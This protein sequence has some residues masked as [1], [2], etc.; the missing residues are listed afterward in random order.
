MNR[1]PVNFFRLSTGQFPDRD[2]IEAAREII[3]RSLMKMQFELRPDVPFSVDMVFRALP[4]FALASG[5]CSAMDC[6]RT[7]E[8]IESNDLILTVA[9]SGSCILHV[10]GAEIPIDGANAA[11]TRTADANRCSIQ[12]TSDLIN[13]RFPFDKIAPLIADLDAATMRP[14]PINTEALRLL[15]HYAAMLKG[16]DMAAA[17]EIQGLVS[18]HLRDLAVLAIGPTRDAAVVASGRGV[19]AARLRAIKAD[20]VKNLVDRQL[21]IEAIALRHGITPRYVSM[22][23]DGDGTTFSEFVLA[24]RLNRAYRMLADSRFSDRTVSSVAFDAGFGDLSYFNRTFR[25]LYGE[26]PSGVRA[27]PQRDEQE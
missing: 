27:K 2:R 3:G 10:R 22:L 15:V 6:L 4:D 5:I 9:L 24:Q 18:S 7:P 19:P 20:I 25:R 26:T 8:L 17:P 23:F 13:F 11:L 1:P 14:I 21:S 12:S 16:E